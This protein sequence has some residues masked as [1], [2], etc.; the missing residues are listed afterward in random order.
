M[1]ELVLE[2]G[3]EKMIL[4]YTVLENNMVGIDAAEYFGGI[5]HEK[6][7]FEQNKPTLESYLLSSNL[8]DFDKI[9]KTCFFKV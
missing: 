6:K 7:T 2:N 9:Y 4:N 8:E 5:L 1:T 3:S